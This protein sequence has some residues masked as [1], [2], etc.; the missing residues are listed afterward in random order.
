MVTYSDT[1]TSKEAMDYHSKESYYQNSQE[2]EIGI[3]HGSKKALKFLNL[4]DNQG[5]KKEDFKAVLY[6][7]QPRT[8]KPLSRDAGKDDRRAGF[9]MTMSPPKSISVLMEMAMANE[10]KALESKIRSIHG[11]ATQYAMDKI[12]ERL[13]TETRVK[14]KD[15]KTGENKYHIVKSEAV[16]ATFQH[17]TNRETDSGEID[18][19]LHDHNF[20][21]SMTFIEDPATGEIQPYQIHNNNFF[22][23]GSEIRKYMGQVYDAELKA[24][25][26]K[27]LGISS[28]IVNEA[29]ANFELDVFSKV[30]LQEFSGRRSELKETLAETISKLEEN[31]RA[32]GVIALDSGKRITLSDKQSEILLSSSASES[33]KMNI[34]N[35]RSKNAKEKTDRDEVTER[36][37]E[38][39]DAGGLDKE[40]L[41]NIVSRGEINLKE[42]ALHEATQEEVVK[43]QE[44]RADIVEK[45]LTML[46]ESDSVFRYEQVM[47]NVLILGAEYEYKEDEFL[48]EINAALQEKR[49]IQLDQN[50]FSTDKLVKAERFV[51]D[52]VVAGKGSQEAYASQEQINLYVDQKGIKF[53]PGQDKMLDLILTTKDQLVSIQGDAGAGKSW[54]VGEIKNI[55]IET[56]PEL[57]IIGM[58][59]TGKAAAGLE[60]GSGVKSVTVASFLGTEERRKK[61]TKPRL[62]V[63][64]ETGMSG[65]LDVAKVIE[66]AR[67]NGDKVVFIGDKKQFKSISAGLIFDDMQKYG[68][69]MTE[70][71]KSVRQK[72]KHAKKIVGAVK[73]KDYDMAF[74]ELENQGAIH[75]GDFLT[76]SKKIAVA[77]S[78]KHIVGADPIEGELIIASTNQVKSLVNKMIHTNLH[79]KEMNESENFTLREKYSDNSI[80]RH[81]TGRLKEQLEGAPILENGIEVGKKD[82]ASMA[83]LPHKRIKTKDGGFLKDGHSYKVAGIEDKRTLILTTQRG[84]QIKVDLYDNQDKMKIYKEVEKPIK[85]GEVI[86]FQENY[87]DPETGVRFKNGDRDIVKFVDYENS[88]V[89]TEGGRTVDLREYPYL[90]YGYA[91]TDVKS[92]GVTVENIIVIADSRMASFNSFYTQVTRSEYN[93]IIWTDDKEKLIKSLKDEYEELTTLNFTHSM[94][95][96]EFEAVVSRIAELPHDKKA[97][98]TL[99]NKKFSETEK[100]IQKTEV[101]ATEIKVTETVRELT[102][103]EMQEARIQ[104]QQQI[105]GINNEQ[106]KQL[107]DGLNDAER[108]IIHKQTDQNN[109]DAGP[110]YDNMQPL[111]TIPVVSGRKLESKLL[112]PADEQHSVYAGRKRNT[113]VQQ[114]TRRDV[115]VEPTV[116]ATSRR[117]GEREQS[118]RSRVAEV[119]KNK[120][121]A[122]VRRIEQIKTKMKENIQTKASV[123]VPNIKAVVAKPKVINDKKVNAKNTVPQKQ[124]KQPKKIEKQSEIKSDMENQIEIPAVKQREHTR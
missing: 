41:E 92:Q 52:S 94:S 57:E 33:E 46:E 12:K 32:N 83:L 2:A 116:A 30:E 55:L 110:S 16:W 27:E 31:K 104:E 88:I 123:K 38:R 3:W 120:C 85:E 5:I 7:F 112:L 1:M 28:V 58:A 62:L 73:A 66:A 70:L 105:K 107:R 47:I 40:R 42:Q 29:L 15:S 84:K 108:A 96:M 8:N 124:V 75:Q 89:T 118:T 72:S 74:K 97:I 26:K 44:I 19:Q 67:R 60:E 117:S 121:D 78:K 114:A 86:I 111:S 76:M 87:T 91:I 80:T 109:R 4:R 65:S 18:P 35:G 6:G 17:D 77:Y 106:V 100:L 93:I 115:E 53:K 63:I 56:Q 54:V 36:N 122:L 101:R 95:K 9:D 64:D 11:R 45:V 119:F 48:P 34:I 103:T 43:A 81:F 102:E 23:K 50:A 24:A 82:P 68:I 59:F 71:S 14:I 69:A 21:M 113:E 37:K 22:K 25:F 61:T 10:N 98:K 20:L 51:I 49:L 99:H 79:G 90:D 39:L 13:Y